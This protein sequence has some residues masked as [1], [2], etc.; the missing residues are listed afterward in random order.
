MTGKTR[1]MF[2]GGNTANGFY[3]FFDYIIPN[4]VNRIF[5]LKGGPGV[6]KSSFMKKM[7]KEFTKMGYDVELHYCS[8]DP[9]SLDGVVIKGLNVVMIDATAPHTVD[10]KI[11]GAVDEILNFGEFW[12]VDKIEKNREEIASCN[13]DISEC[14]KRAFRFLKSE[15]PIYMDAD[16]KI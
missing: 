1:K 15:E 2:P 10:P 14:F 8:S 6:G 12:D 3:S 11:P 5:C 9:S 4:D 13:S 16:S 7:A